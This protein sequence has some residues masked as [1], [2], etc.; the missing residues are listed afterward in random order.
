MSISE[1]LH[2]H[3]IDDFEKRLESGPTRALI[4]LDRTLCSVLLKRGFITFLFHLP[5]TYLRTINPSTFLFRLL[6]III[7]KA[8]IIGMLNFLI[9]SPPG[10]LHQIW[11][12]KSFCVLVSKTRRKTSRK[13]AFLPIWIRFWTCP[14]RIYNYAV[15]FWWEQFFFFRT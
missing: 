6:W 15:V 5:W 4:P 9:F 1:P 10:P 7:K 12:H 2:L 8:I 3:Q 11:P 13:R 14:S